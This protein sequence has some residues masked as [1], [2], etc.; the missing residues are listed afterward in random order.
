MVV[1]NA[2]HQLISKFH[3]MHPITWAVLPSTGLCFFDTFSPEFVGITFVSNPM[4]QAQMRTATEQCPSISL[5]SACNAF[6]PW[7][8]SVTWHWKTRSAS[9]ISL[10]SPCCMWGFDH[11]S[12]ALWEKTLWW[13][14]VLIWCTNVTV[15]LLWFVDR[16][17]GSAVW[18]QADAFRIMNS[19]QIM[20]IICNC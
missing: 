8:S 2:C 19:L 14:V 6:A 10:K 12:N 5:P 9:S 1:L 15:C 17:I 4:L 7:V 20:W 16:I 11:W 3:T 18:C 13:R